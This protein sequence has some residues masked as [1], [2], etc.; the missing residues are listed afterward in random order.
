MTGLELMVLKMGVDFV[1]G[2]I[3]G[4]KEADAANDANKAATKIAKE[5][6]ERDMK[7][8][9]IDVLQG[10]STYAQQVAEVSALRYQDRV[11]K[12]DYDAKNNRTIE[13]ALQNLQLNMEGYNQTYILEEAYRAREVSQALIFDLGTQSLQAQNTIDTLNTR[14]LKTRNAAIAANIESMQAAAGY[15]NNVKTKGME[16]DALVA[17]QD[18]KGQEIQEMI[19]IGEALDTIRRDASAVAA[20]AEGAGVKA[21]TVARQGGSNSSKRLGIEAMQKMGRTYGE[22]LAIQ[23]DRRRSLSSYNQELVGRTSSE[24]AMIAQQMKGQAD[25][26]KYSG[27]KNAG[28]QA[29]FKLEQ[30]GF[31]QQMQSAGAT[32]QFGTRNSLKNFVDLTIPSFGLAQATGSR[33]AEALIRNTINTI[34]GASVPYRENIILDPMEPIAGLKPE[35][36]KPTQRS[37]PGL[38]GIVGRSAFT[39]GARAVGGLG[40]DGNGDIAYVG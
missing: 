22:L 4:N 15:L 3:T 39:A 23:G 9:A 36:S 26:I 28:K 1:G 19:V 32:F 27:L 20:I 40:V 16:A 30:M 35:Y 24:L 38:P 18:A 10:K 8:W 25:Q 37:V 33:K 34:S 31:G 12:T 6:Y 5:T 14:S 7:I 11:A 21:K 29:G 2:L 17:S 13:A